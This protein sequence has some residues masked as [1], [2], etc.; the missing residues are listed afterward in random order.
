MK[1]IVVILALILAPAVFASP[2]TASADPAP[3]AN[4][5]GAHSISG[6]AA[7]HNR[8]LRKHRV[9]NQHHRPRVTAKSHNS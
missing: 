6:K 8:H 7:S 2:Q 1:Q 3:Q 9:G 4:R 5:D